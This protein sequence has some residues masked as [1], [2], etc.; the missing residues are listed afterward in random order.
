MWTVDHELEI[1]FE[2][3]EEERER[4]YGGASGNGR[5]DREAEDMMQNE[6]AVEMRKGRGP[7]P[8]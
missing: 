3:V 5:V 2:R 7:V 8:G 6:Y 4:R 1:W